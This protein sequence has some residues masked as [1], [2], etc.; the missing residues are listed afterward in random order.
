M[1][2]F[3]KKSPQS[4]TSTNSGPF[5]RAEYIEEGHSPPFHPAEILR[6][7]VEECCQIRP[8]ISIADCDPSYVAFDEPELP[9]ES[10]WRTAYGSARLVAEIT[11]ESSHVFPLLE[12]VTD[13]LSVF[14][15]NYDVSSSQASH[16]PDH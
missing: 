7:T 13:A 9:K 12:V 11:K 8:P 3:R 4:S 16:S 10:A 15:R 14:T 2:R 1:R 5:L 6:G